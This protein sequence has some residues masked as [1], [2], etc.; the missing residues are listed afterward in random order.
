MASSPA[1]WDG[2]RYAFI[3]RMKVCFPHARL[4]GVA[5]FTAMLPLASASPAR[6]AERFLVRSWQSEDGLPSNSVRAVAQAADG[7]LWVAT[8]E[9]VVRFDGVRFSG[10]ADESDALLAQRSA[11]ALFALPGGSVWIATARGGLLHWD[12]G[13]FRVV[14]N[15]AAPSEPASAVRLVTQVASDGGAGTFIERGDEAFHV[16]GSGAPRPLEKTAGLV[17]KL[18]VAVTA[19]WRHAATAPPGA[20]LELRDDHDRLWSRTA[21]GGLAV[22]EKAG[23]N[24]PVPLPELTPGSRIAAFLEDREGNLWVATNGNGL[25]QVRPRRVS[26]FGAAE[27]LADRTVLSLIEDRSGALWAANKSGNI[28]RIENGTV[29]HFEFGGGDPNRSISALCE[30]RAGTL[31]AARRSGS[32]FRF[33]NDKFLPATNSAMPVWRVAAIV[34]DADG[35]LC[36]GGEQGLAM[37]DGSTLTRYGAEQGLAAQDVSA[38]AVDAD[39]GVWTGTADGALFHGRDGHFAKAAALGSRAVSALLTDAGGSVWIATLGSGLFH[40]NAGK[41]TRFS[42]RQGLPEDRLTC[43]LDDGAGHLWLGSLAGIF[44]VAKAEL[45]EVSQQRRIAAEWLCFDRTDGMLSREC[46]GG[47]QPAGWRGRDGAL[48][49]PTVNGIATIRPEALE[50]SR[51]PPSVVIERANAYGRAPVRGGAA[52]HA[53]PG[54]SRLEF[55]YTALSFAAPE[56]VRFRTQLEGL[57]DEGHDAGILRTVAYEAVPP[58][59]YRFRVIAA[60]SDGV[61]NETG[62]ALAVTVAPHY[63]ETPWF[64]IFATGFATVIAVTIGAT[65]SRARMRGRML[66]LEAHTSREMER[67]RIAQDLHDDLGASLTEISMLAHLAGEE[68]VRERGRDAL[69]EIA[70]KAHRLVGALDEIVWAANPR[71][72][73]LHVHSRT[74]AAMKYRGAGGAAPGA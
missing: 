13:K 44:R 35:H 33:Q 61:W 52:L 53:G 31:W 2:L 5:L 58:G 48:H 56:K 12:G 43:V 70:S 1:K 38:L 50:L 8:A 22:S 73:N 67:A 66:R 71:H 55:R 60:N 4:F 28:D 21:A 68:L 23:A 39:G 29:T 6:G 34:E 7:Y 54:R 41:V 26:V 25:F 37:W 36:F 11:R 65:I 47:F 9:G 20:P 3:Q 57:E 74:E 17:E 30:D 42:E 19:Q 72:D 15:D 10:F 45:A 69:P 49:F 63:W 16:A 27:G 40:W 46:T 64:Q 62:A 32:V 18:R 24:E 14:W 59:S 51:I